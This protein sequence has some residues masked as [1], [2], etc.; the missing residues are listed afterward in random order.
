MK[1]LPLAMILEMF[2]A[3]LFISAVLHSCSLLFSWAKKRVV[4]CIFSNLETFYPMHNKIAC[5]S[6]FVTLPKF[7]NVIFYIDLY[8]VDGI[9]QSKMNLYGKS[10]NANKLYHCPLITGKLKS[11]S[12]FKKLHLVWI[13]HSSLCIS[14]MYMGID[15]AV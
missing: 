3:S 1:T 12:S 5:C 8:T 2:N 14:G 15:L 6:F 10:L 9:F 11:F 13:D 7:K 4:Y